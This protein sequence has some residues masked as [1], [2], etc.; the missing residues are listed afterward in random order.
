[1]RTKGLLDLSLDQPFSDHG[2]DEGWYRIM[3]DNG[4]RM[5]T[6][7]PGEFHCGTYFPIWLK[8]ILKAEWE[9]FSIMTMQF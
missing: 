1:M 3:N 5:P 7:A 4:Q 6:S 9:K 2:I 8:G